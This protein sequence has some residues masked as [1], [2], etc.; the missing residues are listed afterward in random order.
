MSQKSTVL[1]KSYVDVLFAA[2]CVDC[3]CVCGCECFIP[4]REE[5]IKLGYPDG[6]YYKENKE[7]EEQVRGAHLPEP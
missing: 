5:C 7:D 1:E 2:R 6:C 4:D 3:P